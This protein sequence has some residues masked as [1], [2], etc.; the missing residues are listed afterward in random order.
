MRSESHF[1]REVAQ[2]L[3][4]VL[5]VLKI[6]CFREIGRCVFEEVVGLGNSG[7]VVG[8]AVVDCVAWAPGAVVVGLDAVALPGINRI[9]SGAVLGA[10]RPFGV[11]IQIAVHVGAHPLHIVEATELIVACL[12]G[13]F[14]LVKEIARNQGGEGG[15]ESHYS[16]E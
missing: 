7:V 16:V 12:I 1:V 14:V 5:V 6:L 3:H 2:L 10:P 9:V 11:N 8:E 13:V 15:C 4:P